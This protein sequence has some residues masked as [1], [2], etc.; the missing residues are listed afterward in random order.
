MPGAGP[1]TSARARGSAGLLLVLALLLPPVGMGA[2][3]GG[4]EPD[5]QRALQR[6]TKR[7]ARI[8]A[9]LAERRRQESLLAHRLAATEKEA[10][11]LHRALARLEAA[12]RRL[13]ERIAAL[14]RRQREAER[15]AEV[16]RRHLAAQL[17]SAWLLG[18]EAPV[19][20]LL[21]PDEPA[22]LGRAL[23]YYRYLNRAR[24]ER[25]QAWLQSRDRLRVLRR[26]AQRA[27]E[28]L[29][30][31]EREQRTTL[32]QLR[33]DQARRKALLA[34]LRARIRDDTDRLRRLQA[35]RRRLEALLRSLREALADVQQ[36]D[37]RGRPLSTL[38]GRLPWPL[39]GRVRHRYGEPR[40]GGRSRWR[41][42]LI[43]APAGREV[44]AIHHGRV[45]FADWLRG[46]GLLLIIDHG[47]GY[48]SLYG[49][50]ASLYR[51]VGDW[52]EAGDVIATVGNSGTGGAPGLYFELRRRGRPL[53]P[54][55]WLAR[56]APGGRRA[57]R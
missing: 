8:Q 47:D 39:R 42:L 40:L 18:R 19:R 41:G 28:R 35:D 34:A 27:L 56:R 17:R 2:G 30:A 21:H 50:N 6:V 51:D 9:R 15:A 44:R 3:T 43:A 26:E 7:I 48:L 5:P 22:A 54:L 38:R 52:V 1:V 29:G 55:P 4:P 46:F 20:L 23:V 10:G 14:Q 13:Q 33:E 16:Q 25:L 12:R 32:A 49:R 37:R 24:R 36:V 11:G 57:A 53:D 45:V 31:L